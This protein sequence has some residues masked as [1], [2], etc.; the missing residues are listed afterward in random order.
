MGL[1]SKHTLLL[2]MLELLLEWVRKMPSD[3]VI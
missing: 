1:S 2:E 3:V